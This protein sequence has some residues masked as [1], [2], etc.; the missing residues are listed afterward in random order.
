MD[1]AFSYVASKDKTEKKDVTGPVYMIHCQGQ[2]NKGVCKESYIGETERDLRIRFLED[3]HPSS[4]SSEVSQHTHIESPGHHMDLDKVSV[5]DKE[6][7]YFERGVNEAIDNRPYKLSLNKEGGGGDTNFRM[8]TT[9][10]LIVTLRERSIPAIP[11]TKAV[12]TA[13]NFGGK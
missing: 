10:L 4:T 2:T 11:L 7:H 1:R 5:L 8:S 3:C 12:V 9:R 13:E 6:P